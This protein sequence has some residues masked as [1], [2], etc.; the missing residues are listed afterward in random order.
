[1]KTRLFI[2]AISL[3][4]GLGLQS[5]SK[6]DN[7]AQDVFSTLPEAV[8]ADFQAKF[9]T[10]TNAQWEQKGNILKGEFVLN[11]VEHDIWYQNSGS[12]NW[13]R[14][15]AEMKTQSSSLPTAIQSYISTNYSGWRI[16]DIDFIEVPGDKF[17]E[18]ELEK[19]GERD[20]TLI[21]K[22]DG[23]VIGEFVDSDD[24]DD[25]NVSSVPSGVIST[26][27]SMYPT[28]VRVKWERE[29]NLFEAEFIMNNEKYEAY[30]NQDGT[31]VRTTKELAPRANLLP[32]AVQTYISTNYA[33]WKI[34]DIDFIQTPTVEFYKIELEKSGERDVTLIIKEDGTVI[35]DF[36]DSDDSDDNDDI[37][38]SSVPSGVISTFESMYP[39][40]VRVKW[41][42]EGNLF[43]AEF[44]MNNEKYEAYFNQDGTWVRTTK[45]LAPRAN[46]LPSA[47]QTYIS[48]NYAGWKIDDIDFIQTPTVEFYKIE[49]EKSGER[50]VTIFIKSDGSLVTV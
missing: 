19:V 30:F 13:I 34:D 21:I 35:G 45:E 3:L 7:K 1:M 29:G 16:D 17:Y 37:N 38:V 15:E 46:L 49:L 40:A 8:Q 25:I 2:L 43:E 12:W 10:V 24:N 6:D 36:V 26:F 50:D 14:T 20:V 39:T 31:W 4:L 32:S 48:T 47:V 9:P 11:R 18:I 42:R 23:T 22:E 5:C 41:E 44:I 28:A 33:G 27:E